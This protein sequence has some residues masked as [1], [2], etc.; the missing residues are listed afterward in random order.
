[1]AARRPAPVQPSLLEWAPP[2]PY[3]E[4]DVRAATLAGSISRAVAQTLR[5]CTL[6]RTEVARRMSAFLGEP[7]SLAMLNAYAS[8]AREDHSISAVRLLALMHATGDTRPLELGEYCSFFLRDDGRLFATGE[9]A[10]GQLGVGN[11]TT[12]TDFVEVTAAGVPGW[13]FIHAEDTHTLGIS[14]EGKL[15]GWGNNAFLRL[16]NASLTAPS[17]TTPQLI[18]SSTDWIACY[19]MEDSSIAIR[20]V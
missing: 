1:M 15:Y 17:Y 7:V 5:E 19:A 18:S 11:T 2:A 14:L 6:D 10:S 4:Q 8:Q 13:R 16:G 3:A 12:Q 9:N 20:A